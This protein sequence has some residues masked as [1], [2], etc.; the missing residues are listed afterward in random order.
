[1][2]IEEGDDGEWEFD[3]A[4]TTA[5]EMESLFVSK[6]EKTGKNHWMNSI[7]EV[8]V[9]DG[10]RNNEAWRNFKTIATAHKNKQGEAYIPPTTKLPMSFMVARSIGNHTSMRLLRV[11]FD[12]GG[13][14]TWIN[15]RALP[16]GCTPMLLD[17]PT[18]SLTL[19]GTLK[20]I[21]AS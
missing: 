10:I 18:S 14:C 17:Q 6:E 11:L 16:R 9:L 4:L 2:E 15:A 19:A 1:V 5:C 7:E 13:S 20:T 21:V 12:S 3:A 8:L